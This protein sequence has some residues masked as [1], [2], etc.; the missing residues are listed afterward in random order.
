[1]HKWIPG[2][3]VT[4]AKLNDLNP[5]ADARIS[6]AEH[7]ILELLTEN[8]FAG[9]NTTYQGLWFDGFS[10]TNKACTGSGTTSGTTNSGQNQITLSSPG[11]ANSFTVGN[12][13]HIYGNANREFKKITAINGTILTVDS[14]LSNSYSAGTNI[15]ETSVIIDITNKRLSGGVGGLA[16]IFGSSLLGDSSLVAYYRL[17][18]DGAD[19]KGSNPL[20]NQNGVTFTA[21]KFGNGADL[22]S[23]NGSKR[24]YVASNLGL[25]ITHDTT[26]NIWVKPLQ[27]ISPGQQW[28]LFD[29]RDAT[30][31]SYLSI[32]YDYTGSSPAVVFLKAINGAGGT[33]N[34]AY[35][36]TL[37]TSEF[38]MLTLTLQGSTGTVTGFINGVQVISSTYAN[39][40]GGSGVASAVS[41]GATGNG[42][43]YASAMF[44]DAAIF[45]RILT[46]EEIA[47][48]A[49]LPL[50]VPSNLF[51]YQSRKVSFPQAMENVRLW[52]G[53]KIVA[54]YNLMSSVSAGTNSFILAGDMSDKIKNGDL[55]E[56]RNAVN[57]NRQRLT[58]QSVVVTGGNTTFSSVE[59]MLNGYTSDDF[60]ER[61]DFLPQV[62]L[63]DTGGPT[64]YAIPTLVKSIPSVI[65]GE[66]LIEDEYSYA[67][68]DAGHDLKVE[69][70]ITRNDINL[71]P[72]AKRLGV[73]L[74]T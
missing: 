51:L 69:I 59:N 17:E 5:G 38:T 37:S 68:S 73:S 50:D 4:S 62:S 20:T 46:T 21:A 22:G 10:D 54:S 64:S 16:G 25:N 47:S 26:L 65:D 24:L 35:T 71:I 18:N 29:L 40:S 41:I 44:D 56:I 61:V 3:E 74:N 12:T 43:L 1:M 7:N 52:I 60:I 58:I 70:L 15:K 39:T 34:D 6:Q 32:W 11:Q 23:G 31:G 67:P 27:A 30:Y 45:S 49:M 48:L 63:V 13:V 53:R 36:H 8:Y 55:V 33:T 72:Y 2:E 57:G 42:F 66:I 28:C 9:K 14:N 19:S